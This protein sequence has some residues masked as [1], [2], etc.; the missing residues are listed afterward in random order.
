M[1]TRMMTRNGQEYV[2]VFIWQETET[3]PSIMLAYPYN[4]GRSS[5]FPSIYVIDR[6]FDGEY[7]EEWNDMMGNGRCDQMRQF[8][9]MKDTDKEM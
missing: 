6:D 2:V 3:A 9:V 5:V 8:P 7:D 1:A 4:A